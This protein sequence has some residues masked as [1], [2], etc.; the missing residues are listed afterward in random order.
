MLWY[1]LGKN[2]RKDERHMKWNYVLDNIKDP[3]AYEKWTETNDLWPS[4]LGGT[5]MDNLAM[6]KFPYGA[7]SM[8]DISSSASCRNNINS[9][10]AAL[11]KVDT[12]L[13]VF[14]ALATN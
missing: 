12:M 8:S 7:G 11:T 5:L 6:Q 14:R 10:E 1:E 3:L 13:N 4:F 9:W 2:G